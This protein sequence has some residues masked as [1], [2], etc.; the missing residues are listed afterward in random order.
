M[1]SL[2]E[3]VPSQE[4]EEY[5]IGAK[6]IVVT[7]FDTIL[8]IAVGVTLVCI[9]WVVPYAALKFTC[10]GG[11]DRVL[12]PVAIALICGSC[13][14]TQLGWTPIPSEQGPDIPYEYQIVAWIGGFLAIVPGVGHVWSL[15]RPKGVVGTIAGVVL[16]Y[17]LSLVATALGN[18]TRDGAGWH[19]NDAG[20]A[21]QS[22]CY[23]VFLCGGAVFAHAVKSIVAATFNICSMGSHFP[24]AVVLTILSW[25]MMLCGAY[26]A[27]EH[28]GHGLWTFSV[29]M[30]FEIAFSVLFVFGGVHVYVLALAHGVTSSHV[31]GLVGNIRDVSTLIRWI[32][33]KIS[34]S[35]ADPKPKDPKYKR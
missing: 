30:H 33:S 5:I 4:W 2:K 13:Y 20:F 26:F 31:T 18:W 3:L 25:A 15:V 12:F 19:L 35:G 8:Q 10:W 34:G 22:F 16:G 1:I 6:E 11:I 7:L 23:S 17:V 32:A 29:Y 28:G 14:C 27:E 9:G 24:V 21:K